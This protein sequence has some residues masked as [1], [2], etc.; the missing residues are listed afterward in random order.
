[1]RLARSLV[2][3]S[4]NMHSAYSGPKTP[5]DNR[6]LETAVFVVGKLSLRDPELV[7]F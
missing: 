3:A 6:Q 7:Q 2:S 1:M 4:R 5:D